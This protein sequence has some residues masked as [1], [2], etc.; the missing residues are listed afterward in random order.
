MSDNLNDVKV[1]VTA[2]GPNGQTSDEFS[3]TIKAPYRLEPQSSEDRPNADFGYET[4]IKYLIQDQF[5]NLIGA[6]NMKI[7]E[8]FT[9]NA[10]P[11]FPPPMNWTMTDDKAFTISNPILSD[12]IQGENVLNHTPTPQT[13]HGGNTKVVHWAQAIYIGSDTVG[14]G[15]KV[16]TDTLQKYLDHAAHE[17][18]VSPVPTPTP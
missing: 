10:E 7:N 13:P 2:N 9:G 18:I 16:Q 11:D 8:D 5:E 3:I 4:E 12:I 15:R 17:G 14:A 1:K 6:G